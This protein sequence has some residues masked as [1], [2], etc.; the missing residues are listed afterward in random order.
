MGEKAANFLLWRWES[1]GFLH[2]GY[3]SFFILG[4]VPKEK[5]TKRFNGRRKKSS[6]GFSA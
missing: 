5:G 1:V 3:K 2:I 4:E 6:L